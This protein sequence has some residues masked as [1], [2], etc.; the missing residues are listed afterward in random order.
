MAYTGMSK[1]RCLQFAR[2][3]GL[4]KF[5][6]MYIWDSEAVEVFKERIGQRGKN[7]QVTTKEA[8]EALAEGFKEMAKTASETPFIFD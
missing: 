8:G 1:S 3:Y 5:G 6:Q 2:A 4:P 7:W